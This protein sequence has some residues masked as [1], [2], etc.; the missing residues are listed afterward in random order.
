MTPP[1]ATLE[2]TTL[3]RLALA[4]QAEC[5]TVLM[6]RHSAAI[7][8]R[9]GS[10]ARSAT[11]AEDVMQEVAL[12]VWRHLSTFR[13]E[14]SFRTWLTRVAINEASQVYRRERRKPLYQAV[15]DLD[16]L[17]SPG[18][19]PY[20]SFSRIEMAQ[21]VRG[22]V[23]ELPAKYREVLIL[24]DLEELSAQETAK[25]LQSSIPAVKSRLFRARL[26]VLATLRRS[27]V[28]GLKGHGQRKLVSIHA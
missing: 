28:R 21:A 22:A 16:A 25:C 13:S 9:I 11:D 10:M 15:G 5:F 1:L 4:G 7:R 26:M 23:A 6:D 2:D 24:R 18:E 12:K 19:S 20:Q 8:R 27:T 14:S 17:A 3:V